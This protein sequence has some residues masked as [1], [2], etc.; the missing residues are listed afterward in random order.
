MAECYRPRVCSGRVLAG[1]EERQDASVLAHHERG[2][3]VREAAGHRSLGPSKAT[4]TPWLCSKPEG[5][6]WRP[7]SSGMR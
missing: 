2:V 3:E 4:V 5:E 6:L 7:L 1:F